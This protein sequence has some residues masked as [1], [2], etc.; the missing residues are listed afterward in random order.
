MIMDKTA[1]NMG[2]L[3]T[4]HVP[5]WCPGCGDFGILNAIKKA[6]VELQVPTEK[7]VLCSGIGCG[8]KLPHYV[9]AYG[10]ESLHGRGLPVATGVKLANKELTVIA[11]AGDGDTYGIGMNHFVHSVRRNMDMTM[12]VQN[13]AVYGLTKG[14]YS[15]TSLKGI[16]TP[17]SPFGAI[18][19][20]VNPVAVALS[21]GGT[22]VARGYAFD[23]EQLKN[24]IAGAI[25]H[26]GFALVDALMPCMTFN[27]LNTLDYYKERVYRLEDS[28]Y[29]PD[30]REN[31]WKK[32]W[33]WGEKIPTGLFYRE[34]KPVYEDEY[35][36]AGTRPTEADVSNVDISRILE[37]LK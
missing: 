33:E 7:A 20:P 34:E 25:R 17:S 16:K 10:F 24:L 4:G 32:A 27:K 14:Q 12:I 5:S 6:L 23:A 21:M 1:L 19:A 8:S 26:K 15:P 18:E 28:G 37:S 35:L 22:Y 30:S 2:D 36:P 13:N 11:V 31:A 29:V 3:Q 9:K